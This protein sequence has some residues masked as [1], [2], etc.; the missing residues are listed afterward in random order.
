MLY[1]LTEPRGKLREWKKFEHGLR[2]NYLSNT[3]VVLQVNIFA[4][5]SSFL[6]I[7]HL[8]KNCGDKI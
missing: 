2:K 5:L 1:D 4:T 3:L 6:C 7:L 8:R